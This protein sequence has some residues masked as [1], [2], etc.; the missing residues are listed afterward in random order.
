MAYTLK[1]SGLATALTFCLAVDSDGATVKEFVSSDVNANKTIGSIS[2]GSSSWKGTSRYWFH[3][4]GSGFSPL[5]ISFPS[6]HRASTSE[7]NLAYYIAF[8]ACGVGSGNNG[9]RKIVEGTGVS[10]GTDSVTNKVRVDAGSVTQITTS[11][12][13]PTDGLTAWSFGLNYSYIGVTGYNTDGLA[14][15]Y[16]LESGS[17]AVD[18]TAA[19]SDRGTEPD[20]IDYI[21]GQAGNGTWPLNCHLICQFNRQLTSAEFTSLHNDWFGTL[22]D[23]GVATAV[24]RMLLMGCG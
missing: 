4:G 13:H 12:A 9:G 8:G 2:Y 15:Y 14:I 11:T 19:A 24:P 18:A 10:I 20:A 21:G 23:T 1:T 5:G 22:I 16:G 3:T 6:G 7:G 17:I